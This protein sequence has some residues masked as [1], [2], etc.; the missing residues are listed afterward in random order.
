[1]SGELT[2][3][4]F[5]NLNEVLSI[6]ISYNQ[7]MKERIKAGYPIGRI[8]DIL[9]EM[10]SLTM[11]KKLIKDNKLNCHKNILYSSKVQ[12]ETAW[13]GLDR[14]LQKIKSFP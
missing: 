13:L 12:M 3:R 14:N 8:G 11:E 7:K 4:L 2:E 10:A 1:M 9:S 5:P 6:H